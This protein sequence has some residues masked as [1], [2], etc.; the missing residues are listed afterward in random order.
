MVNGVICGQG[1]YVSCLGE[2]QEGMFQN[3]MLHG[4]GKYVFSSGGDD[5]VIPY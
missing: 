1:K 5:D 4:R 3:G 2:V